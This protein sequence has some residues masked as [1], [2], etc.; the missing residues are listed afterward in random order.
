MRI[1]NISAWFR[2][3]KA[4]K[5]SLASKTIEKCKLMLLVQAGYCQLISEYIMNDTMNYYCI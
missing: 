3:F 2:N 4:S 5:L 1:Q